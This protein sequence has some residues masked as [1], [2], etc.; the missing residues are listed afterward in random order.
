[1]ET[2]Q[3][4]TDNY[5]FRFSTDT[6]EVAVL[7]TE[8]GPR[9]DLVNGFFNSLP[10]YK[11]AVFQSEIELLLSDC[12]KNTKYDINVC[13]LILDGQLYIKYDIHTRSTTMTIGGVKMTF[14]PLLLEEGFLFPKNLNQ[15]EK[16]LNLIYNR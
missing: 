11:T 2:Y 15:V 10:D 7:D 6:I 3:I 5:Y 13:V 1:M 4:S 16:F 12:E 14:D 8:I 9:Q